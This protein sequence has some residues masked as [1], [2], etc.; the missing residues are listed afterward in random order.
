VHLYEED[1]LGPLEAD[2]LAEQAGG[3]VDPIP[4]RHGGIATVAPPH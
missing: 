3:W 1:T 4:P 2:D